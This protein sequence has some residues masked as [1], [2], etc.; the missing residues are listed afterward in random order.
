MYMSAI[1]RKSIICIFIFTSFCLNAQE[2]MVETVYPGAVGRTIVREHTY[3]ATISYVES[4][5]G[6][7]FSYAD[8][9]MTVKKLVVD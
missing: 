5:A 7:F 3:P 8:A 2:Y 6:K 1:I 4:G 9:S